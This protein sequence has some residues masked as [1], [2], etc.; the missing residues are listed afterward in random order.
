[1]R[2]NYLFNAIF[3]LNLSVKWCF[4]SEN[5]SMTP[6][7]L[8]LDSRVLIS[9]GVTT[10]SEVPAGFNKYLRDYINLKMRKDTS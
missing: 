5:E 10:G 3:F 8:T 6:D 2:L 7:P 9:I 4:G 1:M